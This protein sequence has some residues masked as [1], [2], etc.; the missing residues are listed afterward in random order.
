MPKQNLSQGVVLACIALI[1]GF[2]AMRLPIGDFSQV[3]P[4]LFPLLVSGFL[5]ILA[6]LIVG[7]S[8]FVDSPALYF[9]FKNIAII[10]VSLCGFVVLSKVLTLL[11]GIAWLVFV[12]GLVGRSYSWMR[13]LQITAALALIALAFQKLL[14]FNLRL[15]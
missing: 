3:G 1:Y 6:L 10:M 12:A 15:I 14:G 4:G 2:N 9:N 7:Q 5:L 11:A 13:N 8:M